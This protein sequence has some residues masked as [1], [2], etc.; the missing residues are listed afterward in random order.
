MGVPHNDILTTS[1]PEFKKLIQTSRLGF[2]LS[3]NLAS[4]L[5]NKTKLCKEPCKKTPCANV[6]MF[7]TKMVS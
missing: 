1:I 4:L 2:H 3:H 5:T 6:Q 7:R